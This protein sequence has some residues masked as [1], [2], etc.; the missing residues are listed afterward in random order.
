[1]NDA[2]KIAGLGKD[3]Y[4]FYVAEI[5]EDSGLLLVEYSEA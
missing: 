5:A 4:I 3:V 2:H 1:M